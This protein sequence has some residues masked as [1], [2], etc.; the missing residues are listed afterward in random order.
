MHRFFLR[1]ST[2]MAMAGGLMLS[3]LVLLT[4]ASILGRELNDLLQPV[5][6]VALAGWLLDGLGVGAIDGDFE[7]LEAGM[8]FT[9]FA[10]LPLTQITLGHA[11]VDV[12]AAMLP[13]AFNRW[14]LLAIEIAFALV[15]ILIA[16]QLWSGMMSKMG[17]GQTTLRLQF[18]V[19]WGY[20]LAVV[21]AILAA[22]V[23]VWCAAARGIEALT[24]RTILEREGELSPDGRA[25]R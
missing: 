25:D 4:C 23:G 19:W 21:P 24:G 10:F 8:A 6:H 13:R 11:S 9:V 14:L 5:R 18:P 2:G 12:F 22:A 15:L 20:A 17:S 3:A 7:L 1:L 16:V